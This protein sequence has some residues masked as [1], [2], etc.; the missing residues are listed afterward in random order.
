MPLTRRHALVLAALL[1]AACASPNPA[2]FTLA[3]EPGQTQGNGPKLVKVREVSLPHYMERSEIVR[4]TENY[5]LVVLPNDWWGESL[6]SMMNR[7]LV[8]DLSQRL[9]DSTVVSEIGAISGTPNAAVAINVLRFDADRSGAV[10]LDAEIAVN[11]HPHGNRRVHLTVPLAG[12]GTPAL[13]SAMSAAIG[14]LADIV[15]RML[16]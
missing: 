15:A 7:V 16:A 13:V 11:G 5:Q 1:P 9:P 14:K 2:L 6:S 8:Q 3:A 4:S 10:V 12:P